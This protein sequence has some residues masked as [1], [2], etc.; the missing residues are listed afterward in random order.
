MKTETTS[1]KAWNKGK[2]CP[3]LSG[4]NNGMYRKKRL[5]VI[6]LNKSKKHIEQVR[7]FHLGRKRSLSTRRLIGEKSKESNLKK[8]WWKREKNPAWKGGITY[9]RNK[10]VSYY[11]YKVWRDFI[12]KR[13]DYQCLM[14]LSKKDLQVHHIIPVYEN[15]KKIIDIDNGL[16]LCKYCHKM[17]HYPN[18]RPKD[19]TYDW[20]TKEWI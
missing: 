2:K 16:T 5:D 17:M 9:I 7:N 3:Q 4:K 8:G 20:R 6:R 13:D 18:K 11:D 1:R 10:L 19:C 14:C 15:K 12:L